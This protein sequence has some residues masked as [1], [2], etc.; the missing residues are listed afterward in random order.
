MIYFVEICYSYLLLLSRV[1]DFENFFPTDAMNPDEVNGK[2]LNMLEIFQSTDLQELLGSFGIN[3][4]GQHFE[5]KEQAILLV[6]YNSIGLN[7]QEYLA[8][9]VEIYDRNHRQQIVTMGTEQT[10]PSRP[11]PPYPNNITYIPQVGYSQIMPSFQTGIY[12]NNIQYSFLPDVSRN[13]IYQAPQANQRLLSITPIT[14]VTGNSSYRNMNH[15]NSL[16]PSPLH[17][18][19][20]KKLPFYENKAQII[21]PTTLSGHFQCTLL[22]CPKGI[23][24]YLIFILI[25]VCYC[26]M[27]DSF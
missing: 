19:T 1:I 4:V 3:I 20:F 26:I 2:W 13:I 5:L 27:Y 16:I 22:K 11:P 6:K 9:I 23:Y 17:H 18:A 24:I 8:K 21:K 12:A 14:V 10:R 15:E 7:Y 25:F